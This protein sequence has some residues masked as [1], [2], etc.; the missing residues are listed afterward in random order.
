M[1]VHPIAPDS[2]DALIAQQLPTWLTSTHIDHLL[3]LHKALR[4]QQAAAEPVRQ[5][6]KRIPSL[7]AFAT[8]LIEQALRDVGLASPDIKG[9]RARIKES[10]QLPT[11]SPHLPAPWLTLNSRRPLLQAALHNFHEAETRPVLHRQAW[12]EDARGVRLA[13]SFEAFA[14]CC[15]QLDLGGR[16][17]QMLRDQLYPKDRPGAPQGFARQGV[18]QNLE[19]NLRAQMDVAIRLAMIKGELQ[20]PVYLRLLP[21]VA[22]SAIVPPVPGTVTARQLFLLGKRITGVA[23][24][25]L[26]DLAAGPVHRVVAWVPSDPEQAVRSFPSWQALYEHFAERLREPAFRRFFLRFVAERDRASFVTVLLGQISSSA[27]ALTLDGRHFA[28]DEPLFTHLRTEQQRKLLDDARTL[29]VPT[30]DETA[31]E[32]HLRLQ[33][34]LGAGFD[35]LSLAALLVPVLGELMLAVAAVDVAQEVYQGYAAW[36][37]GDRQAALGHLFGVAENILLGVAVGGALTG[38]GRLLERVALVDGLTPVAGPGGQLRLAHGLADIHQL[39]GVGALLRQ[40]GGDLAQLSDLTAQTLA[41]TTGLSPEQLR[42]LHLEQLPAPARLLDACERHEQHDLYPEL[43]GEAFERHLQNRAEPVSEGVGQLLKSFPG[44]SPRGAAEVLAHG[45]GVQV[46][47]ITAVARLPLEIAERARWYL[48]ESRVDRALAGLEQDSACNND[49]QRLALQVLEQLAPWPAAV[50]VELREGEPG[51][52]LL[53]AQGPADAARVHQ[54]VRTGHGY[55]NSGPAQPAEQ[56]LMECLLLTLSE[57]QRLALGGAQLDAHTLAEQIAAHAGADRAGSARMLA[58]QPIGERYRPPQRLA[59]GRFGYPLSGS[60]ESSRQAIRRGIR[61]IFPSLS[62]PQLD[63]Y[64]LDL[65]RRQVGL[66]AHLAQL[67]EQLGAL[68]AALHAWQEQRSSWVD[69]F[70]RRRVA[71]HIRRAWRRK[72]IGRSDDDFI[73][74]ISGEHVG[75]LPALPAQIDFQHVTRLTLRNMA[76]P[77]LDEGFLGRFSNLEE[78]DLRDNLLTEIPAGLDQLARLRRLNLGN[79]RI[80][81]D[82][83]G[84]ARLSS[85][86][87]LERLD[88]SSNPLGQAPD[89]SA[90]QQLRDLSLRATQIAELPASNQLPWRAMVDMRDNQI[91]QLEDAADTLSLRLE[92]LAL[93]DN[94]LDPVSRERLAQARSVVHP[95]RSPSYQHAIANNALRDQWLAGTRDTLRNQ[96]LAIWTQLSQEPGAADLFRFLA[97]FAETEDFSELPA[98]YRARVWRILEL[99]EANSDA[100]EAIFLEVGG[101]RTCEDQMLLILSQLE[102]RAHIALYGDLGATAAAQPGLLRLGRALH[103]LDQV[104]Q[105]A[106]EHIAQIREEAGAAVDDIE[107]YLAYRVNLAEPLRLPAQPLQMHYQEYSGVSAGHIE[108]AAQQVLAAESRET[109]SVA[110]AGREFWQRYVRERH[111]S[112]YAELAAPFHEQLAG[113][114]AQAQ[115]GGEQAYI[116]QANSLMAQLNAQERALDLQ[117]A[118]Q[119]Y[120]DED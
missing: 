55:S 14:T 41:R 22:A 93:H 40:F 99:C 1:T 94:P 24:L 66:W 85:L 61:Q 73:L 101:M 88:L 27:E 28:L 103:R 9:M 64:M 113:F 72:T 12:L 50:R 52:Q 116:E 108:H 4:A 75:S 70:R 18:E 83:D 25:E 92:R 57:P 111:A 35:L 106:A 20:H 114:E 104:D 96:R 80:V 68:R 34:M 29:A 7:E 54:I 100:R 112:R 90:L 63:A 51:G 107:V 109:L 84:G 97:D 53:T 45:N 6:F 37:L 46:E 86:R 16:Y 23:T 39:D 60:G 115:V 48:H 110:L 10:V 38:A 65:A 77:S 56:G 87:L 119:A 21:V 69:G 47:A 42:R 2:I 33:G 13:L 43:R 15:R 81:I 58:M 3:N 67:Q 30:G 91:S 117:L 44:L 82:A 118:R 98:Y 95:L 74:Q 5:L 71:N 76:L 102:V 19:E 105:I 120:N 49:S 89:L 31:L 78:L 32:R 36:R 59:D 8:P 62:E 11:A 26:R 17:Q 79:N